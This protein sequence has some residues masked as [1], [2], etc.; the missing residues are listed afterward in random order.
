MY[1]IIVK[2]TDASPT[3]KIREYP[4]A[5]AVTNVDE[6]PEITNPP[7][8]RSYAEIEYD[9]GSTATNIP[10]VATFTARDE[11]MQD[12][13]W[14]LSGGDAGNFTITKDPN[15]G[16]GVITFKTPPNFEV[17]DDDD[18]GNTYEFTVLATDTASPTNTGAWDYTLTVT[19][20][21]ETPE[22]TGTIETSFTLYEHDA[23]EV[24]TTPP[25]ASY[26]AR[27]EEGGVTWTLTGPDSRDFAID[28]AG[29][30]T[31]AATP[32]FETPTDS[33]RD[34]VY[35]FKVVATDVKSG[36][37]RLTATEDV[38]V[39]VE[40]VEETG[41]IEVDNL[42]PAVGDLI[43][44][45]LMD[46]DGDI[47][48]SAGGSFRWSI[49]GRLP[50]AAWGT[51]PTS[52]PRATTGIYRAD[53]D[54]TGFEIRAVADYSDRR[55]PGKSAESM[56]TAAVAADP[57]INAPPRFQT[58]GTQR[59]AEVG[60]GVDVG[61]RLTASDR[62]NDPVTWG[63]SGGPAAVYF[64]ID[65][66]SGQLRTI[67]A[68]D[69]ETTVVTRPFILQVTLHDGRDADGNPD[70]SVD[71]TT[72]IEFEIID[73]EEL[74]VVTLSPD[75][76]EVG[77][78]VVATFED[79]DGSIQGVSWQWARSENGR[80]GWVNISGATSSSYTTL[81]S[82]AGSFLRASVRYTDRRG[83][84]KTAEAV[85]A[86]GVFS[87]NEGAT[88]PS[89]E[90]GQRAV[91]ENTPA[92]VNIGT[93]VAATDLEDD[94]L[95]YALSGPDAA[96]FTV[97]ASSGQLRTSG[98]LDFETQPSYSFTIEVHD[99]R[100]GSGDPSTMVDDTQSV[101]ITI[102]NVEEPGAVALT[103]LTGAIQARVEVTA[104]LSDDDGPFGITWQWSRSPNGTTNWVNIASNV[105]AT[106]TPTLEEDAGNYI[107]ATATY[108]DG[109][110]P[111]KTASAVSP[112]VGDPP[113]ANSPPAFPATEDGQRDVPEDAAAGQDIGGPVVASDLN[114]DD[115]IY[116]LSG[117]ASALFTIDEDT[118]QLR[119]ASNAQLD[120]EEQRS[121]RVVVSVSDGA[122]RNHDPDTVIDDTINVV[123]TVTD[124]NEAPVITGD[125]SPSLPE[126][127][128]TPVA[129]FTGA[130]PERDTLAWSVDNSDFWISS[131]GQLYFFTPPSFEGGSTTHGVTVSAADDGGQSATLAVSVSVTDMEE[132]GVVTVTPP[133][134]W[135]DVATRF[136]AELT[137]DD[138]GET[139]IDWRWERSPNGR[140]GWVDIAGATSSS[141]TADAGDV[142]AY[143]RATAFYEDRR[144]SNKTA[145]SAPTGRVDELRPAT[146][147]APAFG[148]TGTRSIAQGTAAGRAIGV[149]VQTTDE[150]MDDVLTYSLSGV[151]GD[152][153]DIGRT[154]G[155]LRTKAVL[156]PQV[157][158]IY[159][160]TVSVHDG[161]DASYNP[162]EV[163]DDSTDV[164][165]TATEA[166]T[167]VFGGGGG[168]GGGGPSGPSPSVV[169]F[170]WTVKH[171]LEALD[172]SNGMPTGLWGRDGTLWVA[173][174]GDGANDGVYAYDLET[175]ERAEERQFELDERNRAPRGI[176]SD[177]ETA[178]VSDSGRERV[179]A[180]SLAT[181]DRLEEREIAL[182]E[183]NRDARGIWSD[184]ETMWVLDGG[185]LGM[186]AVSSL[187]ERFNEVN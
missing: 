153:F 180:Y 47:D 60:A 126:N 155:Q 172:E 102:E 150:D 137:D 104:V 154:T 89:S 186:L 18:S 83:G 62:E 21:N 165:I 86:N 88:F 59:I 148:D 44:F 39:T 135:A 73:V 121:H 167:P 95:R 4:V 134:G 108:T 23:N 129:T 114:N 85:T 91:P 119:L 143:L 132:E 187:A 115:L 160:V 92:R 131:R 112:R 42:N 156:D 87:E 53:E 54:H 123:I 158:R 75:E 179:F 71:V 3:R 147:S 128:S 38:T 151:D 32:S 9:S 181:G 90:D 178:W 183:R 98:A 168:G 20:V 107:R 26:A 66:S 106:Y 117:T 36:S 43:T 103:T 105:S 70:S 97:V 122:D 30:V 185:S 28:G 113:P 15:T 56:A 12:I 25:L 82:D 93:P 161:F 138:G 45:V 144:G 94:S 118:G 162:S 146:N 169:D 69:F 133:R 14:D 19:D 35:T 51:I 57:I 120:F 50:G 100:D 152:H 1:N 81:R 171:D 72:A 79:G 141:Y 145:Q 116:S 31:F 24:Y 55:G 159:A 157:Q 170:E 16:N 41:T 184:R 80:T 110:G 46:P 96:A 177:G 136:S 8:D 163:E 109:H 77:D 174:N 58:G 52:T 175:G 111:N 176:W 63:I 173:Q 74:G 182:A 37:S 40:D 65:A 125:T 5:V 11:E 64:E 76:P 13:T 6:T 34:N 7:S 166:S 124:V 17:P 139:G 49:Q 140:S 61:E 142:G 101:T 22:F 68:W 149:P 29:A 33:D 27:D 127:A 67:E 48:V 99:G 10:M 78:T 84:G 130:D 2:A 164:T